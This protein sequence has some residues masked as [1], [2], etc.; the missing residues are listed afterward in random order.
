MSHNPIAFTACYGDSVTFY[1]YWAYLILTPRSYDSQCHYRQS[2]TAVYNRTHFVFTLW[3]KVSVPISWLLWSM[4]K[5]WAWANLSP[6]CDC[7]NVRR[8]NCGSATRLLQSL[9]HSLELFRLSRIMK[10]KVKVILGP[11]VSRPVCPGIRSQFGTGYQLPGPA[12]N[13]LLA[14]TGVPRRKHP[15][16]PSRFHSSRYRW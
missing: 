12:T 11:T 15:L 5:I 14:A 3:E 4:P 9:V 6:D 1:I 10:D 8:I 13:S 2:L 16:L 7:W